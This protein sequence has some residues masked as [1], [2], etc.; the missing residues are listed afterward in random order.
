MTTTETETRT[1]EV[2]RV[3]IKASPEAIWQAITS[4]EWNG[5]Y[6]YHAAAQYDLKP[7][8]KYECFATDEMKEYSPGMPDVIVDGEVIEVDPPN[9][10]VQTYRMH[11]EGDNLSRLTVT[12]DVTD[13]PVMAATIVADGALNEGGG[14]WAWIISDL[15]TLLETGEA[16][17]L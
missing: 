10:L 2:F 6:G 7:G 16:N 11:F 12:H 4:E 8:G 9:R 14:G 5:R 15:K 1:T 3:Y 13:A 17:E